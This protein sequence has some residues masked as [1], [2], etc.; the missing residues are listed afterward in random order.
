[1]NHLRGAFSSAFSYLRKDVAQP[2][3]KILILGSKRCYLLSRRWAN[4][5]AQSRSPIACSAGGMAGSEG[6]FCCSILQILGR[7]FWNKVFAWLAHHSS[8]VASLA[9]TLI[10]VSGGICALLPQGYR[11]A[12]KRGLKHLRLH[13][14]L[15]RRNSHGAVVHRAYGERTCSGGW[16]SGTVA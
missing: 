13:C 3:S 4:S 2:L 14:S 16:S 11:G 8:L 9:L 12:K 5:K 1:M 15:E 7:H 10:G 6:F